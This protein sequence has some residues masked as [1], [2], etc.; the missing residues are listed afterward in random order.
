MPYSRKDISGTAHVFIRDQLARGRGLGKQIEAEVPPKG[1]IAALVPDDKRNLSERYADGRLEDDEQVDVLTLLAEQ[2]IR[3][4]LPSL[5]ERGLLLFQFADGAQHPS[6]DAPLP[7]EASFSTVWLHG[8]AQPYLDGELWFTFADAA[9]DRLVRLLER[10]LW[11][12][13]IGILTTVPRSEEP[14]HGGT[15]QPGELSRLVQS[16]AQILIGAWDATNYLLWTPRLEWPAQRLPTAR[17]GRGHR[18]T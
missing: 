16:A 12:P 13:T 3:E 18:V 8:S 4:F 7:D 2:V 17:S 9:T 10:A 15:L 11:F 1:P 5:D 6:E 14:R